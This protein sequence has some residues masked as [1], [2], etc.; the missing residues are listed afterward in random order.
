MK[1]LYCLSL[2][3][4]LTLSSAAAASPASPPQ[5]PER[6]VPRALQDWESWA[7][8]SD[9][10]RFS[11]TPY[12]AAN[13]PLSFWPSQITL[14][15]DASGGRF[16]MDVTLFSTSWIS[17][18]GD[19]HAWP[20]EVK[21]N[22]LALPVLVREGKPAVRLQ[23]GTYHLEG[24]FPW[25][26]MPRGLTLPKEIGVLRLV[27]DGQ[28]VPAP[29][30]DA[31]GSLWLRRGA[32][33][34]EVDQDFLSVKVYALLEDG[35]PLWLRTRVEVIVAGKS[36]EEDLGVVLPEGWKLA[37]VESPLP[38]MID[39]A[40]R[41]KAQ[42][43]AGRWTLEASAFRTDNP[44]AFRYAPGATPAAAEQL[45][46]FRARPDFRLVE[47]AGAPPIDVSQTTFPSD[48][49]TFPVYRWDT[50]T[51]FQLE[52]RMRGMGAQT[53]QGLTIRRTLWLDENG[54][55]LTFRDHITG[56]MQQIWRL[57][58]AEGQ[59]L[60]A[61]RSN[62][63][64]QLIT[65]NPKTQ[66]PGVEIRSRTLNL[67][68]T[69][70]LEHPG[71]LSATGWQA[72]AD[73]LAVHL[74]L[75]PGWR[76]F[77]L[78]GAD[79][80]L[81]DWLTAWSLLDLFLLLVFTLAVFR[82]W[83]FLPALVAFLAFGIS[84]H[85]PGAPRFVW[86][87][88]LIPLTLLRVVSDGWGRRIIQIGKWAA[89]L[90]LVLTATPFLSK[91]VQ[92]ALFPQLEFVPVEPRPSSLNDSTQ[93]A[94]ESQGVAAPAVAAL[95]SAPP[96]KYKSAP[97]SSRGAS[98]KSNLLYDAKAR[99]QTGPGVPDWSWRIV[100]F[101]WNG[102]VT[103]A[104]QVRPILISAG[105][106]RV[107][108]V[109]RVLLLLALAALLLKPRRP[110]AA[111][112]GPAAKVGLLFLLLGLP[113]TQGTAQEIPDSQT[114]E[115]LRA[116]L[117][118]PSDAYPNAANIPSAHLALNGRHLVLDVEVHAALRVA[119][120]L[121]GQLPQWSPVSVTVDGHPETALRRDDGYL[122]VVV[123]EGI[124]RIHVEGQL[125]NVE[126]WD[127]TFLLKPRQI[128]IDA[129]DWNVSGIRPDGTSENQIFFALK[130]KAEAT[131]AGYD[132][133]NLQPAV[134]IERNLELGLVWQIRTTVKRLSP[135]G[136]AISLRVPL[137]PGENVLTPNSTVNEGHIDILLGAQEPA[138]TWQS[139][140]PVTNTLKLTTRA[141]DPWVE[142]WNLVASPVWNV[143]VSGLPPVFV[144]SNPELVP[145]WH[146]WPGEEA[147]L[148]ISRPQAVPGATVTVNRGTHT[149]TLGTRQ[150]T[151]RLDL[152]LRC[153]LGEDFPISLP[154]GAEV[155]TLT[156]NGA[157]LPVRRDGDKVIIP[158]RPGDL[159]LSLEWKINAPLDARTTAGA[160]TLPVESAN[161]TTTI[162]V[163]D[164][165]WVLWT[166]GPLRGPAVR[167]WTVLACCLIAAWVLGRLRLSPLR[168]LEWMLLAIGLTQVPLGVALVIVA[169]LFFLAWRGQ[170]SFLRL[171]PLPYNLLQV[172]LI[173]TT[174]L[175]LG[176]FI[177]VVAQG[178]LGNPE[179]FIAGNASTR[180][181]LSWFQDRADTTLPTP[182]CLS[183]SIWSFRILMLVWALW[184][185]ASLLRWLR[186]GWTQFSSGGCFRRTPKK[187]VTPP[188][189]NAA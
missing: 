99:I 104:Q 169:W 65:L 37:A 54:H 158:V 187:P 188:P 79:W 119:V 101:G 151:C 34:E 11:P 123:P 154:P 55:G 96:A 170:P 58:A 72:D 18:P 97:R 179:M 56:A 5:S 136:R 21:A 67:E 49:R 112:F 139:E 113:L 60:G 185:A 23:A 109:L 183:V 130:Q 157:A 73:K 52:E 127:W 122:W 42:V 118:E 53:P 74:N 148:A 124:H 173:G 76:L 28:P 108:S 3:V 86:L 15:A 144:P 93:L 159:S 181:Q 48:W 30:W 146:P 13:K 6:Q 19:D 36:R 98:D 10:E 95:E 64:G 182:Q 39:D 27:L 81:G 111:P 120:P 87:A 161:I 135:V 31:D 176:I 134:V 90:A 147:D 2:A 47:I 57:D 78:F 17:L 75:P 69:G 33:H 4:L 140:L 115:T 121:P 110:A 68:A 80:V 186:W 167:F 174:V 162:T 16:E 14:Q 160:V 126:E 44:A 20:I 164:N 25:K 128:T 50:T 102:P 26:Q 142:Q 8:W 138:V 189:L 149:I 100:Q 46:A 22:G 103:A 84:Y 133:Q 152:T 106:E 168:P 89:L 155:T 9:T 175:A 7:T 45:V 66:T 70:R 1:S 114:L 132:R 88:L 166:A 82:L 125:A 150:R 38:V 51:P 177:G 83:G 91:Q 171:S 165:R 178:L 35:I 137:L 41:M 180:T 32:A 40:G 129:P 131:Q 117:L 12:N 156:L 85:E 24:L 71:H 29:T 94:D 141:S 153:S 105:L 107:L 143:T 62:G 116:R 184:L 92:Q 145:V 43:R 163:P 172:L 61:V 59:D 63:Q 77:A